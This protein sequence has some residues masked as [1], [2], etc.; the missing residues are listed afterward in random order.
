MKRILLPLA[1]LSLVPVAAQAQL[2]SG[3]TLRGGYFKGA[4]YR[5][6][7]GTFHLEG[8]QFGLDIP[9]LTLPTGL[10]EIRLSPTVV[11]GGMNRKGADA[12]G[13]LVRFMATAKVRPPLVGIYGIGGLGFGFASA[14]GTT[15]FP[16]TSSFLVQIGAGYELGGGLPTGVTPFVEMS[17][18][19]G[20]GPFQG[21][22]F[23]AGIRF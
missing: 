9:I 23:E 17:Y 8:P 11:L 4:S 10:A 16:V 5:N 7:G 22:S 14:R 6:G 21:L 13:T 2:K 12:D 18:Y 3:F 19:W 1:L 15:S 20:D